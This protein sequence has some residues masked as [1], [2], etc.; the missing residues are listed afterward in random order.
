MGDDSK[1]KKIQYMKH[2]KTF[3][4]Q[5]YMSDEDIEAGYDNFKI[6]HFTVDKLLDD[7]GATGDI[8]IEDRKSV[9]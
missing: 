5:R 9:V 4:E 7:G 2:L 6:T 1:R 3:E 8:E